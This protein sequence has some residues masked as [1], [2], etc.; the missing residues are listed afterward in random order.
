MEKSTNGCDIVSKGKKKR[1]RRKKNCRNLIAAGTAQSTTASS[2]PQ[3]C[4]NDETCSKSGS[5]DIQDFA[6]MTDVP[7]PYWHGTPSAVRLLNLYHFVYEEYG[8]QFRPSSEDLFFFEWMGATQRLYPWLKWK[9]ANIVA[10]SIGS[11]DLVSCPFDVREIPPVFDYYF[12]E[13]HLG[14]LRTDQSFYQ[15]NLHKGL[16]NQFVKFCFALYQA[17]AASLSAPGWEVECCNNQVQGDLL[18]A[19]CSKMPAGTP[20]KVIGKLEELRAV[21][22]KNPLLCLNYHPPPPKKKKNAIA[23]SNN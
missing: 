1:K 10:R 6:E 7:G 13:D 18:T 20:M 22:N 12:R 15:M 2:P 11:P 3:H 23:S 21:I 14:F 4:P 16:H 19:L 8:Y 17:K 5:D 9:T